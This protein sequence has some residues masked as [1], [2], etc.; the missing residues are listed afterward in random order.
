MDEQ[1]TETRQGNDESLLRIVAE[2]AWNA[3]KEERGARFHQRGTCLTR[4]APY[5]PAD[6]NGQKAH[7]VC[8][9][10]GCLDLLHDLIV[11]VQQKLA[12][13]PGLAAVDDLPAYAFR[14]ARNELIELGRSE[15]AAL[16]FPAK[17]SRSDGVVA[18]VNVALASAGGPRADWFVALFRIMRCYPFSTQ[19][20]P[21]RWPL[22]GLVL[23]RERHL[24]DEVS[25]QFVVKSEIQR[26]LG[27]ATEVAGQAW[28]Y[29]TITLPLHANGNRRELRDDEPDRDCHDIDHVMGN[30][31]RGA[32]QAHRMRGLS[33]TE[34]F[35]RAS[36]E[37]TGCRAPCQTPALRTALA[38]LDPRRLL[39]MGR[40]A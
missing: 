3:S 36:M 8:Q 31:L 9:L 1:E 23:E 19:H 21:G 40:G 10:A 18:R 17:P 35:T 27:V 6:P 7:E 12:A 34:A 38:D 16:G 30:L 11:R 25:T 15:R 28:V 2:A 14:V 29:S 22:D 4:V 13:G 5:G 20:I 26:V 39:P 24:P 32:Y 37:V 33:R